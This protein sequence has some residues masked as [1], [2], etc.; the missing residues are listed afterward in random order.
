[1]DAMILG[2]GGMLVMT[3]VMLVVSALSGETSYRRPRDPHHRGDGGGGGCGGGC[4]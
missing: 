1:M 3:V 4:S 2:L